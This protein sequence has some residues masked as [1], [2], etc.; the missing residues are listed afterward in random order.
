MDVV[1]DVV[2]DGGVNV[3]VDVVIDVVV[4]VMDTVVEFVVGVVEVEREFD[5]VGVGEAVVLKGRALVHLVEVVAVVVLLTVVAA[6]EVVLDISLVSIE[7]V[8]VSVPTPSVVI[9]VSKVV[10]SSVAALGS[11]SASL[12]GVR[13]ISCLVHAGL[14]APCG[15]NLLNFP[16]RE[17]EKID[18]SG[19]TWLSHVPSGLF[20]L[21][22]GDDTANAAVA[23][24]TGHPTPVSQPHRVC[25]CGTPGC[26]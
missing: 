1:V 11:Q 21:A 5:V 25:K 15:N 7:V 18:Q 14:R 20:W 13:F 23:P 12:D 9:V 3:V 2:V 6:M 17:E 4:V 19:R 8:L 22:G 10:D 26:D 24:T 16:Q